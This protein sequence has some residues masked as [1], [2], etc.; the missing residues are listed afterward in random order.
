MITFFAIVF[1]VYGLVN[2]Y[3]G[4]RGWQSFPHGST[5][6]WYYLV[7]FLLVSLSF[8]A[9]RFLER[10]SLSLSNYI[11][12]WIGSFWLAAM[13]Y[14][15][16]AI[17]ILDILRI[18][19]HFLPFFPAVITENYAKAKQVTA[20]SITGLVAIVVI[21]GYINAMA[22]KIQTLDL[23]IS[24]S[25]NGRKDITIALVSDMHLGTIIGRW[26]CDYLA[27][28][29]T[30]LKPDLILL[31]GD[32][33]DEDLGRVIQQ[34]LGEALRRLQAP[35]GVYGINGNHEYFGGVEKADAYLLDH[36]I[37]ML[38][39]SAVM[40]DGAV[41]LV[42][43]EDRSAGWHNR[44]GRK[45]LGELMTSVDKSRPVILLDHQPFHLA[46]AA[47]AGADLQ[48]SGHT[49]HGQLW[50]FNY[51]T[52]HIYEVSRGY[53]TIDGMHAYVSTGFGTWGPPV[54]VGH[55]P[56]IVKITLHFQP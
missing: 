6:R 24:K 50:P 31:A 47:S 4:I 37:T 43:R 38:R 12:V 14:F 20:L 53:K 44:R 46:E 30:E 36:G 9:G 32:I 18:I 2:L 17:L 51:I 23:T 10:A 35:L 42:G 28:R 52:E 33:V 45:S 40:V 13:V 1:T 39:D 55:R 34:N 3:I 29:I 27:D 19:N 54:R 25:A 5:A 49:H 56:E 26:R 16:F 7:V 48:L 21:G 15:F 11:L 22:T 41:T 8:I